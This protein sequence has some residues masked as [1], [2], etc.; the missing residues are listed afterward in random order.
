MDYEFVEMHFHWG[1]AV[2][3]RRSEHSIDGQ[4]YDTIDDD[5]DTEHDDDPQVSSGAAHGS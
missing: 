5:D 1:D 3:V 2:Q 4:K